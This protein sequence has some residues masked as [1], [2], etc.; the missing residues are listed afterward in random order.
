MHAYTFG[1]FKKIFHQRK[2]ISKLEKDICDLN[3]SL[4]TLKE[5]HASLVSE[6]FRA[7][8][9]LVEKGVKMECVT[10]HTLEI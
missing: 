10:C 4:E 3:S 7:S 1:A 6:K 5:A 2:L 9:I 8:D